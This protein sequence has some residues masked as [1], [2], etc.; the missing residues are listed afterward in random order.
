MAA[1]LF[2]DAP[3]LF[4]GLGDDLP[5]RYATQGWR[6]LFGLAATQGRER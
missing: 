6:K 2:A 4:A 3:T 5:H 1:W